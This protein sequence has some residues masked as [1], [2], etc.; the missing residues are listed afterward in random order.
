MCIMNEFERADAN[1]AS[2]LLLYVRFGA[3]WQQTKVL[4]LCPLFL[5]YLKNA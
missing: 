1:F 3:L 2:A 4:L 5:F